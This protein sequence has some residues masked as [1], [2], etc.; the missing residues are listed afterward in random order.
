MTMLRV[1]PFDRSSVFLGLLLSEHT[2]TS[3]PRQFGSSGKSRW[4]QLLNRPPGLTAAYAS[5]LNPKMRRITNAC[6]NCIPQCGRAKKKS[7]CTMR[8]QLVQAALGCSQYRI[9]EYNAYN[10]PIQQIP[11]FP[12]GDHVGI[13]F[14]YSLLLK[15]PVSKGP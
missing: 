1:G 15:T 11:S 9:R 10:V 6:N 13:I 3:L 2:I 12:T 8:P 14:P 5:T 4:L 7:G